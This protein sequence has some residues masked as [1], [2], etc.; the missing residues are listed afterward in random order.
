MYKYFLQYYKYF[1]GV[2]L[3]VKC[4]PPC[5]FNPGV[6]PLG[7]ARINVKLLHLDLMVELSFK[8]VLIAFLFLLLLHKDT[9]E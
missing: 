6:P 3:F 8:F 4:W 2:N 7:W 9:D 1:L 5:Q